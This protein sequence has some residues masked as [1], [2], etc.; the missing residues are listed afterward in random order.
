MKVRGVIEGFYGPP[1][2]HEERLGLI[3]F[4][5]AYGL[6]T[7]VHA[8]KDDPYHRRL[9]REPYPD[10]ELGRI[11][12]LAAEADRCGVELAYAIAPGLSIRAGDESELEALDAKREQVR[13]AG[14]R[15]F[16]L[17]WDDI[18][19]DA[20][21]PEAQAEISNRFA[22]GEPL[23]VC[24]MGYA[25]TDET[26]YRRAFAPSLDQQIVL[27]WTGPEVVSTGIEREELDLAVSSFADH[28]LVL[29]DNYPV[30]DWASETLF[31]G[32]LRGRDPRLADGKLHGIVANPMVQCVPSKLALAT[33]SDWARDPAAYDAVSS[34]ERALRE[35]GA[36]VV[37]ALRRLA[38]E[39]V[40]VTVPRDVPALIEAL[41]LGVD[42]AAG[43]GL[44]EPFV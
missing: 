42:A 40:A 35:H 33:V 13:G 41:A 37:E 44:L 4:C 21:T 11:R 24:P 2:S 1:W 16:Q 15:S 39:P 26:P 25:G 14:V 17:L 43:I 9:W 18:D 34:Y 31:L 10:D 6:T 20:V 22:G 19:P 8:P 23:V 27:Y 3:R 36:E 12:E 30:N 28:E 32:P 29:W 7:W 38:P 5:G